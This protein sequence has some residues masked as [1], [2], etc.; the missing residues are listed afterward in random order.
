VF[1]IDPDAVLCEIADDAMSR[2]RRW[3][4]ASYGAR[5]FSARPPTGPRDVAE[6]R[7]FREDLTGPG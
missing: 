1:G 6:M 3:L 2:G 4:D 5:R 7:R